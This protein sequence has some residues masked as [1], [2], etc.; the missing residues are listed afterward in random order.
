MGRGAGVTVITYELMHKDTVVASVS[1]RGR[2]EI[3]CGTFLPF[4][5]WLDEGN[6]FDAC[7]NNLE[8]FYHWCAS[9]VLTL[10]RTYAKEILNCIG[11]TQ[12][13]T[14]R[15]RAQIALAYRCVSLTDVYWVRT[16]GEPVSFADINLYTHSLNEALV[17]LPLRGKPLTVTN[18][19]LAQDL[20]TKGVFPKAWVRVEDGFYLL[21][22]G[23]C[24]VV[25]RELLA[26]RIARCF[27]VP[28][29]LYEPYRYD[30]QPVTQSKLIT[31]LDYSIVTRAAFEIYCV[32]HELDA[33]EACI[34]L[35]KRAYYGMNIVDYLVG[36]TDRHQENWG[37]WVDNR[38]NQPVS[39]HPL[40]DF[41]QSFQA[42]DS[43]AGGMC[44]TGALPP[45]KNQL[46]AA[47]EAVNAVGLL[48]V[49][50]VDID[51]FDDMEAVSQMFLRRLE[52]LRQYA[53]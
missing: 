11:A 43:L 34:R 47:V 4:D 1:S 16:F 38:T 6:D 9:R 40:M 13:T 19:E 53:K 2:V 10:D 30:G 51:W 21:K 35:D 28:Q 31:S 22:D 36:N 49:R 20:A 7:L 52:K 46:E 39:L 27:D 14:D 3:F 37:I 42:Y 5:L 15:D 8:N 33:T 24:D 18:R 29:V 23:G 25:R 45:R 41:N 26:S 50:D 44:L 48:Q 32:N 12:S 17:D